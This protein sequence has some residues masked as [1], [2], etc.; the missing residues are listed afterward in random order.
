MPASSPD[1]AAHRALTNRGCDQDP[2]RVA[3]RHYVAERA[4]PSACDPGSPPLIEDTGIAVDFVTVGTQIVFDSADVPDSHLV[5]LPHEAE[6]FAQCLVTKVTIAS[7]RAPVL[8]ICAVLRGPLG[9]SWT[10]TLILTMLRSARAA[11]FR[12]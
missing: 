3:R 11:R 10:I 5:K 7:D 4:D 8:T 9:K 12:V 2:D 6:G 1:S